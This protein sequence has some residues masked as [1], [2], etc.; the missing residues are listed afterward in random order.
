MAA[1]KWPRTDEKKWYQKILL[2]KS[3]LLKRFFALFS[4]IISSVCVDGS[5]LLQNLNDGLRNGIIFY[6]G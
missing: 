6:E 4:R 5:N 3:L 2:F 1:I